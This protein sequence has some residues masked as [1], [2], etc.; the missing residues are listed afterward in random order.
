MGVYKD[1]PELEDLH[2]VFI[3]SGIINNAD[4]NKDE[5]EFQYGWFNEEGK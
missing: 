5:Q 4:S 1:E 3:E 2:D